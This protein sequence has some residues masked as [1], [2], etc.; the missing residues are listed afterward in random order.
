MLAAQNAAAN[1]PPQQEQ[2]ANV[3]NLQQR[4]QV[5]HVNEQAIHVKNLNDLEKKLKVNALE[6][7]Q[8]EMRKR[9]NSF[10]YKKKNGPANGNE[11]VPGAML[12]DQH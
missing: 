12:P 4:G 3:N 9:A 11:R 6:P 1:N 8:H 10:S 2:N 5:A 7:V